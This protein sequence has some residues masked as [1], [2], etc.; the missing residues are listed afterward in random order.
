MVVKLCSCLLLCQTLHN[1][2]TWWPRL[3]EIFFL[4]LLPS[5]TEDKRGVLLYCVLPNF[6][7][8]VLLRTLQSTFFLS[9]SSVCLSVRASVWDKS[10]PKQIAALAAR[11]LEIFMK[12]HWRGHKKL[13][14]RCRHSHSH[15]S[16]CQKETKVWKGKSFC[17][18]QEEAFVHNFPP[19]SEMRKAFISFRRQR[20]VRNSNLW[21]LI[22]LCL[23]EFAMERSF[24]I[25][26]EAAWRGSRPRPRFLPTHTV[27]E[28]PGLSRE[29]Y[30]PFSNLP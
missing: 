18:A 17:A 30:N 9:P 2:L 21:K 4:L 25:P 7:C 16:G 6:R 26:C 3:A 13:V 23:S 29:I 27:Q 15:F 24:F 20:Q 10:N 12:F 11:F 28:N 14:N 5:A 8:A 22:A 1:T 19:I